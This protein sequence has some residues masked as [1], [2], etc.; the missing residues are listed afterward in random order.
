MIA[1]LPS[2]RRVRDISRGV[3][4]VPLGTI[5]SRPNDTAV[6]RRAR[7]GA[8]RASLAP[9]R[10][11]G[12]LAGADD[13]SVPSSRAPSTST[14]GMRRRIVSTDKRRRQDIG[15][16]L[17]GLDSPYGTLD[18]QYQRHPGRLRRP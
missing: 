8:R 3:Y 15:E 4:I 6:Q 1:T 2:A 9:V 18:L 11:N 16:R 17:Y 13:S 12:G 10:C 7:E 5:K 14:A